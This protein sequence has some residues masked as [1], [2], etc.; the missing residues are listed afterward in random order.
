MRARA[1]IAAVAVGGAVL[2]GAVVGPPL[3]ET[4]VAPGPIDPPTLMAEAD[5][6]GEPLAQAAEREHTAARAPVQAHPFTGDWTVAAASHAHYR[7]NPQEVDA[8]EAN[9]EEVSAHETN[10]HESNA[11]EEAAHAAETL[12]GLVT[13][14]QRTLERVELT[15]D[16]ATFS[17]LVPVNLEKLPEA[18]ETVDCTLEG[19]I[20]HDGEVFASEFEVRISNI[21]GTFTV[22]GNMPVSFAQPGSAPSDARFI[23]FELVLEKP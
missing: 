19:V 12:A 13:V 7:A 20:S 4:F 15:V 2:V 21:D 23:D 3:Y 18:G 1:K 17:L 5:A 6:L 16:A 8:H 10:A 9:S 11:Q 22:S 14:A